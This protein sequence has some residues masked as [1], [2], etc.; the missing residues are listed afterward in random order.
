M[1]DVTAAAREEEAGSET[2]PIVVP[3]RDRS[4]DRRLAC[5]RQAAQPEDASLVW[6]LRPVMY[7]V[8]DADAR[9]SEACRLVLLRERVEGRIGS[10]R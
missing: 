6:S 9:L 8:E 2:L 3:A 1:A 10:V 7:L 4:R 5:A